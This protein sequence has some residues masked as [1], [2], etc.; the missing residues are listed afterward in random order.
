[1]DPVSHQKSHADQIR[2]EIE[3]RGESIVSAA[4]IRMLCEELRSA[5]PWNALVQLALPAHWSFTF[6]PDGRVRLASFDSN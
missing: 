2:E 1:M 4:E 3:E 6:L 5:N